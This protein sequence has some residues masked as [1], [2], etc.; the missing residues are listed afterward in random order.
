MAAL[1]R[2]RFVWPGILFLGGATALI[3]GRYHPDRRN[4]GRVGTALIVLGVWIT[5]RFSFPALLIALGTAIIVAA[6]F[7]Q[8]PDSKLAP[9]PDHELD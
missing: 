6:I 2:A 8:T 9:G 7:R 3:V 4:A 1:L 5:T